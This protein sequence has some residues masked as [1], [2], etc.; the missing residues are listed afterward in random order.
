[1]DARNLERDIEQ[2]L[3]AHHVMTL[4]TTGEGGVA[5]AASLM[6]AAEHLSLY[7]MSDSAARHSRHVAANPRVAATVAPDYADFHA[8]RGLQITGTVRRLRDPAE[9][10]HAQ[11]LMR[12]R[13]A[14]LDQLA[15]GPAALSE[16][17]RHAG[18][19]R[20]TP[21]RITQIDNSKG[22]GH[23]DSLLVPAN[24]GPR[25]VGDRAGS[26]EYQ[27]RTGPDRPE[28]RRQAKRYAEFDGM[29]DCAATAAAGAN[30]KSDCLLRPG[31]R[32]DR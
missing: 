28:L 6:F 23:K 9:L 29:G 16:A 8:I 11:Q 19:Y 1:M 26:R 18:H 27:S 24:R 32:N 12:S 2:F 20:L 30:A 7:W 14:F 4:A 13:Y 15:R 17:A 31:E 3:A 10:E 25:A 21:E 22:F 5:H